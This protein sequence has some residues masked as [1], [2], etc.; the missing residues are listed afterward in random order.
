MALLVVATPI[1]NKFDITI[2]AIEVFKT[3]EII[4]CEDTRTTANLLQMHGIFAKKLQHFTDHTEEAS[5]LPFL[6]LAKTSNVAI[7][8]DAGTPIIADPGYKIIAKALQIG[9][10]V[11]PIAG[12]SSLTSGIS[13]CGLPFFNFAFLH[14]YDFKKLSQ[15]KLCFKNQLS[16][17]CFVP[18]REIKKTLNELKSHFAS[19]KICVTRELTK[20]YEDIK[21]GTFEEL[22][23]HYQNPEKQK[24]EAV[25]MISYKNEK[26]EEESLNSLLKKVFIEKPFLLEIKPK[27]LAEVL[28]TYEEKFNLFSKK[29]IYNQIVSFT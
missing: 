27:Q 20:I 1:G 22:L 17:V 25:L 18:G 28:K 21:T 3:A 6:E 12:A 10:Q 14:F 8:S 4:L 24:G 19:H 13:V 11:S 29:E 2:R 5:F 9:V 16:V 15:I 23:E 7:V 26:L